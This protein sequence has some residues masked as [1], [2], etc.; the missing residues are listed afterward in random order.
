MKKAISIYN[1]GTIGIMSCSVQAVATL[2]GP[3]GQYSA[4]W[5][6][7]EIEKRTP[8]SPLALVQE[9]TKAMIHGGLTESAAIDLLQRMADVSVEQGQEKAC[10]ARHQVDDADLP[11]DRYFRNAWEWEE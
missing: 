5:G 8:A 7:R 6:T 4:E 3:G 2:T 9:Y 11:T 10:V 1:D